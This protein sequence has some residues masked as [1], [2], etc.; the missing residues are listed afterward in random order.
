MENTDSQTSEADVTK[1]LSLGEKL[2][3]FPFEL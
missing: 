1:N 2:L 3:M